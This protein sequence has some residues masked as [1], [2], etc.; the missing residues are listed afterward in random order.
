MRRRD[1]TPEERVAAERHREI[2][3]ELRRARHD[4]GMSPFAVAHLLGWSVSKVL[5]MEA[6]MRPIDPTDRGLLMELYAQQREP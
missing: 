3:A 1:D 2:R 5:W 6:G 4:A